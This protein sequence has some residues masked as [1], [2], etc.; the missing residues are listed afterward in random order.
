[1]LNFYEVS[2]P[3]LTNDHLIW[4]GKAKEKS[5]AEYKEKKTGFFSQFPFGTFAYARLDE[6]LADSP[7]WRSSH[8]ADGRD[9][10]GLGQGQ[11]N[12]EIW[13][14]ECF[15]PK[16]QYKDFPQD[17]KHVF[18]MA[19]QFFNARSRGTVTLKSADP[20]MNPVVDHKYLEDPLDMLLLTEACRFAN[21]IAVDGAGTKGIVRGSWPTSSTH[22]KFTTREEWEA[23][24]RQRADTCKFTKSI[25]LRSQTH[26]FEAIIRLVLAR[27]A[28]IMI[29]WLFSTP[30]YAFVELKG[31]VW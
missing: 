27:W 6:R 17:D 1:M 11:P 23:P 7:L 10:M 21:E 12:I 25:L 2:E 9:P 20:M 8:R 14:T 19:T 5:M 31:Y 26:D 15:S 16:Y 30:N 18:A 24:V 22:H 29:Q 3:G 13:N 28:K 4:H